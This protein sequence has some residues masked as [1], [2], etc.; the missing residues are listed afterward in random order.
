MPHVPFVPGPWWAGIVFGGVL[1]V[2]LI[3]S[4]WMLKDR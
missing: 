2:G 3:T 1:L 4:W